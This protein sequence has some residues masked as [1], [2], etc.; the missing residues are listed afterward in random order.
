MPEIVKGFELRE[1][2]GAPV[3]KS[4]PVAQGTYPDLREDPERAEADLTILCAAPTVV[5]SMKVA[6]ISRLTIDQIYG[7][8]IFVSKVTVYVIDKL[9]ANLNVLFVQFFLRRHKS[10]ATWGSFA[11]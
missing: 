4:H 5:A 8:Q 2:W 3:K 11:D 1:F 6:T 7:Y 9:E 10:L